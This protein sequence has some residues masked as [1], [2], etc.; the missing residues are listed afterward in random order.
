M[1]PLRMKRLPEGLR[2]E[3]RVARLAKGLTQLDLGGKV[4]LSQKHVSGIET[5]KIV[6]R[7]DT[8]LD[9]LRALDLDLIVVPRAL[10]PIVTSLARD[11][12][13]DAVHG[14]EAGERPLYA[15]GGEYE[16]AE[17][18]GEDG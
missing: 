12:R 9:L 2:A 5:G 10:T 13:A 18:D 1:K 8:L 7:V 4:G 15:F 14:P 3:I 17:N 11:H 6:P 16:D